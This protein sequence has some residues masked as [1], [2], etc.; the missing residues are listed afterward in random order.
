MLLDVRNLHIAYGDIKAVSG[1]SFFLEKGE[2]DNAEKAFDN[3][4][5][6]DPNSM[7]GRICKTKL[8]RE[9]GN[10]AEAVSD[11]LVILKEYPEEYD[12]LYTL[13]LSYEDMNKMQEAMDSYRKAYKAIEK[14]LA[15]KE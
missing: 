9:Q 8:K 6:S 2:L 11:L 15:E 10:P 5:E 13:G 4:L 7:R 1:V 14:S 3:A 12:A